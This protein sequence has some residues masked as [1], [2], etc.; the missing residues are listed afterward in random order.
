MPAHRPHG[1]T[2]PELLVV[3]AIV[4]LLASLA[5]PALGEAIAR[6][7]LDAAAQALLE[8]LNHARASAVR[9]GRPIHVC[10]SVDGQACS[11]STDW[12]LGWI[13]RDVLQ[14]RVFDRVPH[15]DAKLAVARRAGRHTIQFD[16]SGTTPGTNQTITL[17]VGGRPATAISVVIGNAG[18]PHRK[19]ADAD[20]A[21]A[22][23]ATSSRK[24]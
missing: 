4:G 8:T 9:R 15:L 14:G 13:G 20:D 10:T 5:L 16:P 11:A 1:F 24:R 12:T 22:C 7:H 18:R 19:T 21:A 6:R 2:W 3:M 23:A 17:C